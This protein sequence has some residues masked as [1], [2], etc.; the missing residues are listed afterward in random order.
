MK[1]VLERFE[2]KV[3]Y[4]SPDGCHYWTGAHFNFRYG[5]VIVNKIPTLAHRLAYELYKGTIG[6]LYVCHRC[7]NTL[8]VNP[9][10]LFLG[11][12]KNNS[13]DMVN[14]GRSKTMGAHG[15][16]QWL[17]KLTPT[18]V[19]IIRDALTAGFSQRRIANYF[20]VSP[21]TICNINKNKIWKV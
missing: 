2:D 1:T 21:A 9:N 13:E 8:C 20:K 4:A 14:K 11:T 10:H 16:K 7:D 6:G 15:V 19:K 3:F 18:T 17:A 5:R 12:A